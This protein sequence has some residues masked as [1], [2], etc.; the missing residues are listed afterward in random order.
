MSPMPNDELVWNLLVGCFWG[1]AILVICGGVAY[2]HFGSDRGAW[3][4]GPS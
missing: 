1:F 2:A 4:Y 3:R